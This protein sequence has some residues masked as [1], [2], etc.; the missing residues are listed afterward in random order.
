MTRVWKFA[1]VRHVRKVFEITHFFSF[2]SCK[3]KTNVCCLRKAF[4]PLNGRCVKMIQSHSHYNRGRRNLHQLSSLVASPQM[5]ASLPKSFSIKKS[6]VLL[7]ISEEV[8]TKA[9]EMLQHALQ[10]ESGHHQIWMAGRG[11][12]NGL[13]LRSCIRLGE[14][15]CSFHHQ[16]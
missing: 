9:R 2:C 8:V 3:Y 6:A 7:A 14:W 13:L 5:F 16:D 10:R 1:V 12:F 11:P 15:H 4:W